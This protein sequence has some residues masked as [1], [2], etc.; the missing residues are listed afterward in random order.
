MR[1]SSRR[2]NGFTLVEVVVALALSGIVLLGARMLLS[3]LAD[4]ERRMT[5]SAAVV[6]ADANGERLLRTLL[7]RLD[8]GASEQVRFGGTPN[9]VRFTTWCDV[10]AGWLE[11]CDVELAIETRGDSGT[12]VARFRDGS[13]VPL[14]QGFHSGAFRYL[15]SPA[16]GGEWFHRWG[17]GVAAPLALGV[18]LDRDTLIVRIGERG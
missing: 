10:P 8:M 5:E 12:L 18:I 1:V 17:T 15:N 9:I 3:E 11:R 14:R 4:G 13:V 2:A 6:E 16:N 7:G